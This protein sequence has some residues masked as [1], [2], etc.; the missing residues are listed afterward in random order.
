MIDKHKEM[1]FSQAA[2]SKYQTC[3]LKFRYRHLDD[4]G[5][6]KSGTNADWQA[7]RLLGEQF[8]MLAQRYFQGAELGA[9]SQMIPP[10][11]LE[12]WF[13]H[14]QANFPLENNTAYYPEQEFR[15][16]YGGTKLLA[17]Y[18]LLKV[19]HD[20]RVVIYDWKTQAKQTKKRTRTL[21]GKIY[22]LILCEAAPFGPLQPEDVTMVYWNPRFP[23]EE[24]VWTYSQQLYVKDRAEINRLVTNISK[25]SYA[26]F[27]GIKPEEGTLVP[28]DCNYCEFNVLCYGNKQR[29]AGIEESSEFTWDDIE[30]IYYE[31]A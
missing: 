20:G 26:D 11:L 24:E 8:H 22:P 28:K 19:D 10:G 23:K 4:L 1:F 13:N 14:L 3:P 27:C 6:L 31:E 2:L 18:D 29:F 5:W 17:K 7:E 12:E 30:E 25:K 16:D 15:V 9:L 21:Q